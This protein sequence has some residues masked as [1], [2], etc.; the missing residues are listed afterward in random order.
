MRIPVA[1][2]IVRV[3][4]P[5]RR[6]ALL[7]VLLSTL[8]FAVSLIL[9]WTSAGHANGAWIE[10]SISLQQIPAMLATVLGLLSGMLYLF[11]VPAA[12]TVPDSTPAAIV[13]GLHV[14]FRQLSDLLAEER[15]KIVVIQE[16]CET[17]TRDAV[18]VSKCL[19]H[20]ADVA[21]DAEARLIAGVT[22]ASEALHQPVA[23]VSWAAD[24]AQRIERALPE[25]ADLIRRGISDQSQA[26]TSVL[27]I[28]A[29]RLV[30]EVDS[31]IQTFRVA[32]AD[33][34][35]QIT[36]LG[37]SAVTL[38]RDVVAFDTAG[39]EI[40]TVSATVVSRVSDAV[41]RIDAALAELPAAA[42]AVSATAEQ[43]ANVLADA[44][45]ALAADGAA[46]AASCHGIEQAAISV[47]QSSE[48]LRTT[49]QDIAD[50]G[51]AI[52]TQVG[53][54]LARIDVALGQLPAAAAT[55]T[56]AAENTAESIAAASGILCAESAGLA[57]S[58][59]AIH[60]A[61]EALQ[62]GTAAMQQ[63]AQTI[64]DAGHQAIDAAANTVQTAAA[65]LA[66]VIA[67]AD[68][69][70]QGSPSM[71]ELAANLVGAAATLLDG[72]YGLDAAGQRVAAAGE[73]LAD[74]LAAD[75]FR[76]EAILRELPDVAAAMTLTMT[77]LRQETSMLC[78][79]AHQISA[80]SHDAAAAA[81]AITNRIEVS[82]AS[83]DETRQVI[84]EERHELSAQISRLADIGTQ[85][86]TQISQLPDVTKDMVAAVAG[87]QGMADA[88]PSEASLA[89]LPE[90]AVRLE[91]AALGLD[92]LDGL[93]LQLENVVDRLRDEPAEKEAPATDTGA[94]AYQSV[95]R[96]GHDGVRMSVISSIE[97]V[98]AAAAEVLHA[99][100]SQYRIAGQDS[101]IDD[102]SDA[103]DDATHDS[104]ASTIRHFDGI[105]KQTE[106]LLQQ[107]EA[108]AEAVISGQAP[109]LPPLLADRTPGLLAGIDAATRRLQ[110]VATA[111]ALA[112][113]GPSIAQRRPA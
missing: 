23:T 48:D 41:A 8:S 16:A 10:P 70:R 32:V 100:A 64:A 36:A 68:A 53:D 45:T 3:L 5:E 25:I 89:I 79:T 104:L 11:A 19:A 88:W 57:A 14:M 17:T 98:Q 67:D 97:R 108:L 76:S 43:A 87:L 75:V 92:R 37:D 60:T 27:E 38:S 71:A 106:I 52:A 29:D 103:P 95:A 101:A 4:R 6:A 51:A 65:Q 22:Q 1:S 33:A 12:S 112:S 109:G 15:G 24:A 26:I 47:Q 107:S 35:N 80:V 93:G 31:P 90:V 102:A 69:A 84:T 72:T 28:T 82:A 50:A 44:S 66:A 54:E 46:L 111:V 62:F 85:A 39:R 78:D 77:A 42:A 74:R 61:A 99:A 58:G 9:S 83:L 55:V 63:M 113:D 34:T 20:L 2:I 7:C 21:V 30:A 13:P 94:S 110:S 73:T 59:Q 81:T 91:A 86:E 49:R 96:N 18:M 105:S 40:A 56:S